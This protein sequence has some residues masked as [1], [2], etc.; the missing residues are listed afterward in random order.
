MNPILVSRRQF[1]RTVSSGLSMAALAAPAWLAAAPAKP[2]V[3][4]Q[5]NG[6]P[7]KP[8]DFPAL[9]AALRKMKELGYAGFECNI[10]FVES[11]FARLGEARKRIEDTGME[12]I[13]TH[14]SMQ[15][16]K[17]EV[18]PGWVEKVA[19][20]G[21]SCIVMSG[22]GLATNGVFPR[23]ALEKKAAALN[24]LGQTCRRGGLR[25]AYHNHNPEF[26]NHNAE[27]EGLARGT[28]ASH[29]DFLMDA[30]HGR[31]GGGDP[32]AFMRAFPQRILGCHLK[33][34]KAK[35]QVPLG[36]GDWGFDDLAAA[37]KSTRWN[38]WLITEEGGGTRPGNTAALAPDR[39]YIRNVFGV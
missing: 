19:A 28:D 4:C 2:R 3:G 6:F 15:L 9:L 27:I 8:N 7:L 23:D 39:T 32:A 16:A 20:L 17:A 31:L 29:V 5:A 33:T 36:E 1:L 11:E 25:L 26:A 10:R 37:V 13:G 30:G 18:F 24:A 34:Y 12:F 22:A 38:G 14:T 21:A 35:Q